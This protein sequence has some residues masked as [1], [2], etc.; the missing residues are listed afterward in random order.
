MRAKPKDLKQCKL[1]E[2][3]LIFDESIGEWEVAY[4]KDFKRQK[5]HTFVDAVTFDAT[6]ETYTSKPFECIA[7]STFLLLINLDVTGSPTDI[8]IDVEFS[9]DR[10][11]WYKYMR[12]PFGDLRWED[13]AGD[14]KECI[15]G[16][17]LARYM[18]LKLTSSGCATGA[19]FLMTVK[20]ILNG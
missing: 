18:R 19:T 16:P 9:D 5:T 6:D 14:K 7:Y 15:D 11:N 17:V 1:V 12:G 2:S 20:A 4:R 13:G 8:Y 3:A 10:A